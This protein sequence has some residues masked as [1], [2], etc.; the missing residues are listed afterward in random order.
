[1]VFGKRFN[2]VGVCVPSK[3]YMVDITKKLVEIKEL[4]D[5]GFYFTMNK[6]RQYGKTTT[7]GRLSKFLGGQYLVIDISFE[8]VGDSVFKDEEIFSKTFLELLSESIEMCYESESSKLRGFVDEVSNIKQ[9]SK[10]ITRFVRG[11]SK[12]VV[13]IIDEVDK[14]SNNQLFLSFLGMLRNKYLNRELGKDFTFRTVIL[15][16]VHDVKNLKLK[17]RDEEET[18]YNSPWNIAVDFKID[19]SFSK[20]EIASM[21]KVYVEDNKV[22]MDVDAISSE[23]YFFTSGNPYLVSRLCQIID[24]NFKQRFSGVFVPCWTKDDVQFAV[25]SLLEEKNTLFE[26]LIKKFRE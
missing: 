6:P 15:A 2:T 20:E 16:G 7:I 3:H 13:L 1:M 10:V 25:K 26:S 5:N 9:L 14:S 22:S 4:I 23:V 18:K 17:L 11:I 8:G 21:L 12:D 24:E 19:M